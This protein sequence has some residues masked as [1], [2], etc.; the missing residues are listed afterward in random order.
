MKKI[1]EIIKYLNDNPRIK[2]IAKLAFWIVFFSIFFLV[3]Y[4]IG[5]LTPSKPKKEDNKTNIISTMEKIANGNYEFEYNIVINDNKIKMNGEKYEDIIRFYKE[6]GGNITKYQV[7]GEHAYQIIGDYFEPI[8]D[9]IYVDI[10]QQYMDLDSIRILLSKYRSEKENDSYVFELLDRQIVVTSTKN[11]LK[12]ITNNG[13]IGYELLY[14]N[15]NNVAEIKRI[16][17]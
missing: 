7:E 16:S 17:D 11:N 10:E 1:K 15:F 5:L 6:E 12:I 2:A 8:T 3:F 14:H 13:T 4:I 9:N